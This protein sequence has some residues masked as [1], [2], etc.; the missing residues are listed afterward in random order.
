MIE[1]YIKKL[2]DNIPQTNKQESMDLI[3]DGGV[4]NGSYQIGCL[5]FLREMEK[6]QRIK[7]GKISGCSI[8]SL[9]ALLYFIDKLDLSIE[10]YD[11]SIKY[12]K[13]HKKLDILH[14]LID[15]KIRSL[16]PPDLHIQITKKIYITYYDVIKQKKIVKYTYSSV[17]DILDTI[18][19]SSFV[20]F[21]INGD[22]LYQNKYIDGM[23][24]YIFR[25][26]QKRPKKILYIDLF[27][28]DKLSYLFSVK[29]E[30]TNFHRILSGILD[31]H[32]FFIKQTPTQMCSYV[33]KWSVYL[34]IRNKLIKYLVEKAIFFVVICSLVAKKY[35]PKEF[36]HTLIVKFLKKVT[37][38][39]YIMMLEHYCL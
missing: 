9:C 35:V 36:K 29:N 33:N 39:L 10:I 31:I 19:K 11:Y 24:P 26:S 20:P 5:Y 23:N 13:K 21:F 6:Q 22:Y 30:K 7:I 25:C 1:N 37:R 12:F 16:L 3:L 8:G 28:F 4:F 32:L 27:G 38:D 14:S 34:W 2:I 15:D 18:K 17:E